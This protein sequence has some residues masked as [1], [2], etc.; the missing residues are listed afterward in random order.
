[1]EEGERSRSNNTKQKSPPKEKTSGIVFCL[2]SIMVIGIA[3]HKKSIERRRISVVS[4]V[5]ARP[6][7]LYFPRK[8]L[9]SIFSNAY[10]ITGNLA[11]VFANFFFRK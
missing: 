10:L 4:R 8:K 6:L 1:M 7:K 5:I 9:D 2:M 11:M 3:L